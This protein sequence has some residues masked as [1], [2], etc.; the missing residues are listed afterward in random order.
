VT[1]SERRVRL[2]LL[3]VPRHL[4]DSVLGDLVES[5]GD[6]RD[7]LGIALHFQ[8]EPYRAGIDR[9]CVL[10]LLLAAAGVL[11]VVPMAAH[12][13]LAQASVFVEPVSRA[14][15]QLWSLPALMASVACGLLVGR[16]SLLPAHADAARLHLVL[17]LAPAAALAAP[18][19]AQAI[20]AA[21][22]LPAAA[23]L[24]QQNRLSSTDDPEAA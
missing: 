10:L 4:R 13:L 16:A 5:N 11:W 23:W 22:L 15:L 9:R 1:G 17:L 21:L 7:A 2:L 19:A 14:V 18:S 12:S 20:L 6:L 3:G 8:A 24:A